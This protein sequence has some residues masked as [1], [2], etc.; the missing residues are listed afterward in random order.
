MQTTCCGPIANH[1]F[2]FQMEECGCQSTMDIFGEGGGFDEAAPDTEGTQV[3]AAKAF[4]KS[5][6]RCN[7][8]LPGVSLLKRSTPRPWALRLQIQQN[9]LQHE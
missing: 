6:G 7:S 4:K 3:P 1:V 5:L 9:A 8:S 2:S